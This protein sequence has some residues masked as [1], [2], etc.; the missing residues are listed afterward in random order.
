[1]IDK[2]GEHYTQSM[3]IFTKAQDHSLAHTLCKKY[4][5][6]QNSICVIVDDVKA[7]KLLFNELKLYLNHDEVFIFP[8][9]E[10]LPYDHFS[11]PQNIIKERFN[12]LNR[13]GKK[14]I[15]ITSTKNL[16]E[17]LPPISNFKSLA[18]FSIDDEIDIHEFLKILDSNN[19][20][21]KDKVEFTNEYAH[22]GGIV[23]LY[24]PIYKSPIRIEFF[25]N[26]IESIRF[27]DEKT[28]SSLSSIN[29]FNLSNGSLIPRNKPSIE[30]FK[31]NWRKYFDKKDERDCNIFRKVSDGLEV[32]GLEIYLPFFFEN[33]QS[34]I[35][36]FSEFEF[37]KTEMINSSHFEY[38]NQRFNDENIDISRPLINPKDLF[39]NDADVNIFMRSIPKLKIDN[40][41]RKYD[42]DFKELNNQLSN[43]LKDFKKII[44]LSSNAS[45]I[46]LLKEN[47]KQP[48]RDMADAITN[49]DDGVY[50]AKHPKIRSLAYKDELL[51]AH[52]EANNRN[53]ILSTEDQESNSN[54]V[55]LNPFSKNDLVIHEKYGLGVY[56]GLEVVKT[57]NIPNEYVKIRYINN[58]NLYVPLRN[59][60]LLSKYHKSRL[61]TDK[62]LDSIS[63]TKWSKKKEKA[64]KQ[65]HDHA[66]EILDIE[67]RR[68]KSS[69][70][71]LRV[72]DEDFNKFNSYFPYNETKD[73]LL[74]IDEIRK[75]LALVKPM[76]RLICGDV[77]F[78]KT[79]VSM[80]AAF[81]SVYSGK[82]VVVLCPSTI[83]AKQHLESFTDRFKEFPIN[84]SLLNRHISL[85]NR[86]ELLIKYNSKE[87]DI[88]ICTHAIFNQKIDYSQT[89]LLVVDEEHRF[90]MKQK[91][92]IK[93]KQD[94]IHILY[95]SATPIPR[96]M[97]FVFSGLKDFSF[98][99]SPPVNRLSIKSFLKISDN[100]I[101]K[102][103]IS[104]EIQRGGQCFILQNNISKIESLK[105]IILSLIPDISIGIAHGQLNKKDIST[106]M[107]GFSSG[108]IDILICT[109]IVEMGL[110]I[111][112]ANT[113]IIEDS[114]KL[115]LAQLHQLRG[116][117]GRSNKQG[118]C[119]FLI[120]DEKIPKLASERLESI[121]RLSKLGSGYFIAQE[122]MELRGSGE[123][124]G[125][126]QSGHISSIGLSLYLS[127]L[128]SAIRN[129]KDE[130]NIEIIQTDVNFFDSA[131]IS[132]V[133]MPSTV[134]RLKI[135]KLIYDAD[136][137]ID[138]QK[139]KY[140]LEDTCGRI[141]LETE[142][143][144]KNATI[145]QMIG[146]LQIPKLTSSS[147]ITS[148]QLGES[149]TDKTILRLLEIVKTDQSIYS[150]DS[151]N[152]FNIRLIESNGSIRRDKVIKL[153]DDLL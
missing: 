13:L 152:R 28:Q 150:F 25:D 66:A 50:L 153:L 38:I 1:M 61:L 42:F 139:I 142:N 119:Y 90:G 49:L 26:T 115:G 144:L 7:S 34:L 91:D 16:Y 125:E 36:I 129:R 73:Q 57:N 40:A 122:D 60:N 30:L 116:R 148:I 70:L 133:Y 132:D 120:P 123:I 80:R 107:T 82:Q 43:S 79:E 138:I 75:D 48:F 72:S 32:E 103:S 109:T 58:E 130:N 101:L 145:N 94:N 37:I 23:D 10:I 151:K 71:S 98:L 54:I 113:M 18:S 19:F 69:S 147:E 124:L 88:L 77:G 99:N 5:E 21:R 52:M 84:V 20:K 134:E 53:E 121:V 126:K 27:F 86:K 83:L 89:G 65:A 44:L 92:L 41:Y 137:H 15:V 62:E 51:I 85:K 2:I 114:H 140:F 14:A 6:S 22:R 146:D 81:I 143:L 110:D 56:D 3:T 59:I 35:D 24:T 106:V 68:A 55:D 131:F 67:S 47:I 117:I 95:L 9:S 136:T 64:I 12:I 4:Q 76:N 149:V 102:E 63:S 31:S 93:S 87:I 105:K 96:T 127:M 135:Y 29:S 112:N 118:Y 33:T 46:N 11:T 39:Y 100:T 128:K 45:D 74:A 111:P 97:N 17:R 141:P 104:R 108:E 8:E 78:G